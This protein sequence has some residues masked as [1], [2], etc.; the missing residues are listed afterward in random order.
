[1][2]RYISTADVRTRLGSEKTTKDDIIDDEIAAAE[3]QIDD[4]VSRSFDL[5]TD[6]GTGANFATDAVARLFVPDRTQWT[7]VDDFVYEDSDT[8]VE[9][10]D[11]LTGS[12]TALTKD[13]DFQLEP[14]NQRMNN[15]SWA[16]ERI[17]MLTGSLVIDSFPTLRITARFGWP[18]VPAQI[19]SA[20]LLQASKLMDRQDSPAGTMGFDGF[21]A[22]V[23]VMSGLDRDAEKLVA[24]FARPLI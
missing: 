6:F 2:G 19:K 20:A 13:T 16:T 17:R 12:W 10:R 11:S 15:K 9:K 1:M 24:P 3:A 5:Y 18:E 4:Y 23:R 22:V 21:G 8:V 7:W 14:I